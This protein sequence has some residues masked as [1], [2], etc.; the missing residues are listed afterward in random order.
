MI[1]TWRRRLQFLSFQG[2]FKTKVRKRLLNYW[3]I[4]NPSLL[5]SLHRAVLIYFRGIWRI[6]NSEHRREN[7]KFHNLVCNISKPWGFLSFS[8]ICLESTLS[9]HEELWRKQTNSNQK[10]RSLLASLRKWITRQC[11][12]YFQN[13]SKIRRKLGM[14]LEEISVSFPNQFSIERQ[15]RHYFQP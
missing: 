10:W 3:P 13:F 12:T 2:L 6:L 11:M 5:S 8:T 4:Y 15:Y 14:N 9:H 1:S 7:R